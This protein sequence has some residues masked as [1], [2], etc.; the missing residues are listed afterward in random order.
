MQSAL[1][2]PVT[3][4]IVTTGPGRDMTPTVP[5]A[6]MT[7]AYTMPQ[8]ADITPVVPSYAVVDVTPGAPAGTVVDPTVSATG[9]TAAAD[10]ARAR[11]EGRLQA[12]RA[13]A[14]Y[15]KLRPGLFAAYRRRNRADL[16]TDRVAVPQRD[17]DP[18]LR[19]GPLV[20]DRIPAKP[21]RSFDGRSLPRWVVPAAVVGGALLLLRR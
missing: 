1:Y 12:A 13:M 16:A 5:L 6:V 14:A 20:D 19:A 10:I 7:P 2:S 18:M 8:P 11:R 9:T 15:R 3:T 21:P 4:A 17:A